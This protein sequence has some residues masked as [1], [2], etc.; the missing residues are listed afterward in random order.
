MTAAYD[1]IHPGEV[2]AEQLDA[3]EMSAAAAARA[4]GI[5]QSRLS[6]ILNGHRSIMADT[7][8]RLGRWL[9]TDDEFWLNL[10][11]RYGLDTA[12]DR[13]GD[14]IAATVKPLASSVA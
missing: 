6:Q 4:L 14:E 9:G 7:A 10:Q 8:L 3:L 1:P 12:R 13:Q 5:P 2:L 11:A